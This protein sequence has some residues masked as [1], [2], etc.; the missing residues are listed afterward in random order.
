MIKEHI[1]KIVYV[2]KES[3]EEELREIGLSQPEISRIKEDYHNSLDINMSPR[4]Y[5]FI[6][7]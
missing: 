7:S 5:A 2:L 6:I 4:Y 3:S 1:R